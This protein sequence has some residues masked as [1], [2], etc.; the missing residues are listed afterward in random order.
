MAKHPDVLD[1]QSY[2]AFMTLYMIPG[3]IWLWF[4]YI[5]APRG[6]VFKTARRARSPVYTFFVSTVFWI[7]TGLFVY[8]GY[9]NP[10]QQ[11]KQV[12]Q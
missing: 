12:Q 2:G 4:R 7:L 8:N 1:R 3:R 10:P 11:T 9:I 6:S 5:L